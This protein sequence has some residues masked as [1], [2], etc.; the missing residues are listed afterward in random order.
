MA[1]NNLPSSI[2]SVIQTGFL[3]HQ[4]GLPLKAQLGFR[5]IADR[6]DFMANIGETITKTRTGLLPAITT[7]MSPAANSD[8]TSGL[9]AQNYA[10]EQY[11]LAIAQYAGMMQLNVAT[12]RVAI[13]DLFLRNAYALGEQS[14]RSIDA[15]AQ[16]SLF[17]TYMGGNT[18]V[19]TTLGSAGVTIAVDDIRGFQTTLNSNGQPVAVSSSNPVNVTVGA[20]VYS[21]T[22]FAADGTN[23]STTPGGVSG[24]LTF[25]SSVSV[26]DGT[27]GNAVISAVAP[28]II[29]PSTSAANVMAGTT[30]AI[31]SSADINNGKLTMQMILNAK[32]TMAANGVPPVDATGMYV[33]YCDPLQATGLYQDPAFQYFFR[34]QI[35]SE[36]YRRGIVAELL[37]VRIQETNMNPVQTLA[38]VGVVRRAVLCGQGALV[39]GVFTDDAY[40]AA[41]EADDNDGSIIVV[42]GI[43]HVTRE[44][45]DALKQVVTQSW[46]YIGGFVA[47]SDTTANPNTIPTATN[48]AFKRAIILESL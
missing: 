9:T 21:L 1:V 11:A 19:R 13:A 42:D 26:S 41:S 8:I 33:L 6:E 12:S 25:S 40:A 20:S 28:Y 39:E 35:Q 48:S 31:S 37:G 5:A 29:R 18:R 3:E 46:S 27:A 23:V 2:Q 17:N 44:P 38:S 15:L 24:T 36:E 16:T 4:F 7:A 34:G 45:L 43:A 22:G 14:F 47:P 32:A 30:A 10:V